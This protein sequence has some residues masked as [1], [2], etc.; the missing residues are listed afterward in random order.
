MLG[1]TALQGAKRKASACSGAIVY[2]ERRGV[3]LHSLDE[4]SC[5]HVDRAA[6]GEADQHSRRGVVGLLSLRR[7]RLARK[8]RSKATHACQ[9]YELSS[10]NHETPS[11]D[12]VYVHD[13]L[14]SVCPL[15]GRPKIATSL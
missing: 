10:R 15:S 11:N 4:H 5:N 8:N 3:T 12:G 13:R 1:R 7:A 9:R 2:D 6:R 14:W